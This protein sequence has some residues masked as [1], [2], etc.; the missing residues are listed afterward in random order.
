M[1]IT[2]PGWTPDQENQVKAANQWIID[3]L[4]KVMPGSEYM[5]QEQYYPVTY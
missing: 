3:A 1:P 5:G 2:L 4:A